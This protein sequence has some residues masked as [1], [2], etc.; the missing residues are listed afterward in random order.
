MVKHYLLEC[1][2][3]NGFRRPMLSAIGLETRPELKYLLGHKKALKPLFKF[4]ERTCRLKDDYGALKI[5][6]E[7]DKEK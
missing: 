1:P 5:D 3:T 7:A 4:I 2:A 6:W